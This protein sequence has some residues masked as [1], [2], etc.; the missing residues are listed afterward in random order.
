LFHQVVFETGAVF[1]AMQQ[2]IDVIK[3][4]FFA[5]FLIG[6]GRLKMRQPRIGDAIAFG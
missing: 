4:I 2:A 1:R 3:Q 5:D 6:I